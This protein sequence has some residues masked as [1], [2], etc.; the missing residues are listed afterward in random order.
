MDDESAPT[1]RRPDRERKS[2]DFPEERWRDVP[3]HQSHG[4]FE[5]AAPLHETRDNGKPHYWGHRQRVRDRLASGG[6]ESMPD[7]ELVEL[8]L[9]TAIPTRDVNP[10]AKRLLAEFGGFERLMTAE[11][12]QLARHPFVDHWVIHQIKLAEAVAIRLAKAKVQD[13]TVFHGVDEIIDYLR[14]RLGHASVEHTRCLFLDKKN[15][16]L[17]D[18]ELGR[19]T[20][21]HTPIYPREIVKRALEVGCTAIVLVHNHPS[22]DARPSQADIDMTNKI[23]DACTVMGIVVHD[24]LII[25]SDAHV[26]FRQLGLID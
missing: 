7:Y 24:H 19:G 20:V 13:S 12:E 9:F 8:L 16:L 3:P 14:V 6:A 2:S 18:E 23:V 10:L 15:K 11:R 1:R 17:A 25:S 4:F 5:A 21:D 22:G 26:S